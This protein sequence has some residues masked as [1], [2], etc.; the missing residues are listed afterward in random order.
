MRE[1]EKVCQ[2]LI[3]SGGERFGFIEFGI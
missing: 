2:V 1:V 3:G